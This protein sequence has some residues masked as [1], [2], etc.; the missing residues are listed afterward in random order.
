[1]AGMVVIYNDALLL[2]EYLHQGQEQLDLHARDMYLETQR[3]WASR[4]CLDVLRFKQL[5]AGTFSRDS[6]NATDS[7]DAEQLRLRRQL[8]DLSPFKKAFLLE[9]QFS[10][11]APRHVEASTA[12]HSQAFSVASRLKWGDVLCRAP[13]Q[14]YDPHKDAP[15]R[16]HQ[17]AEP[18]AVRVK[19][20]TLHKLGFPQQR[21]ELGG[22]GF[23]YMQ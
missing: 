7:E 22:S 17:A 12:A 14:A 6:G 8:A 13:E 4:L 21:Q 20:Q 23:F 2:L 5:Y 9:E 3:K 15:Y 11:C 1:M 18:C 16:L 19:P 10:A